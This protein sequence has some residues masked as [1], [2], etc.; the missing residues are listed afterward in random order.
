MKG[1]G[2]TGSRDNAQKIFDFPEIHP[3]NLPSDSSSDD[4][5]KLD[6]PNSNSN[7]SKIDSSTVT[8]EICSRWIYLHHAVAKM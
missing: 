7:E 2:T 8:E 1:W 4:N 6:Y 5:S 3:K